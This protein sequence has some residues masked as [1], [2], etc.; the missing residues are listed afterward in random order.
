VQLKK[1]PFKFALGSS[2]SGDESSPSPEMVQPTVPLKKGSARFEIGE[3]SGS[4]SG[5]SP[6]LKSALHSGK[7]SSLLAGHKKQTS[8]SNQVMTRTLSTPSD[9]SGSYVDE[10][11]IDDD[12]EDDEWEDSIEESGKSSMDETVTFEHT[13]QVPSKPNLPS[14]RSLISLMF[15]GQEERAKGLSNYA[16]HSTPA[17]T[18]RARHLQHVPNQ[19]ASPNDSDDHGIE[20][21]RRLRPGPTPMKSITEVPRSSAQPIV[22]RPTTHYHQQAALSPR[23]TRRNMLATELTESLRRNLLWE[24]QQKSS[25]A[26]AVLKRRHTS[27]DVA[28]LKQYP[29]TSYINKSKDEVNSN[30][31]NQFLREEY[32]GYH[33]Q[34]W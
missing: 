21:R 18:Q 26:N 23:T 1:Q 8:F 10:S 29:E 33:A 15:A 20:M 27:H 6:S 9:Q 14:Q 7:P 32:G 4:G 13:K 11:A 19:A 16:S 34:G 2:S 5:Q 30:N 22:T 12:D 28:N 17:I 25:T 24:R 31:W 3:S